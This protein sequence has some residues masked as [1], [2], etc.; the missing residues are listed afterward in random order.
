MAAQK[1]NHNH[2][3]RRDRRPR[4]SATKDF[5]ILKL[6]KPFCNK[7]FGRSREQKSNLILLGQSRTPVPTVLDQIYSFAHRRNT[8]INI[9]F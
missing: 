9:N 7:G 4:L 6:T 5:E 2:H 3:N 1:R 8:P